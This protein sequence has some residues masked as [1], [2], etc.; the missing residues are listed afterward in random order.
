V[1]S[2]EG[3]AFEDVC[4]V[5]WANKYALSCYGV[6]RLKSL[7]RILKTDDLF[8]RIRIKRERFLI[9]FRGRLGQSV[10]LSRDPTRYAL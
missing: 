1:G 6:E 10:V 3:E 7:E 5:R 4:A 8:F 9:P 2:T